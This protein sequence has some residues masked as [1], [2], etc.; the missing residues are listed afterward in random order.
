MPE[1]KSDTVTLF[2]ESLIDSESFSE[3][4]KTFFFIITVITL[5]MFT[6]KYI[7]NKL[8]CILYVVAVLVDL[9]QVKSEDDGIFSNVNPGGDLFV[10]YT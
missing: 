3:L 7:F 6:R 2:N 4:T 1:L 5:A 10:F 8:W 9:I